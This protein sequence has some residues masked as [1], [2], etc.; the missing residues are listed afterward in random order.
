M[1]HS[2]VQIKIILVE[3]KI[4][5]IDVKDVI[6]IVIVVVKTAATVVAKIAVDVK[7][8][9]K[10]KIISGVVCADAIVANAVAAT[11]AAKYF[12]ILDVDLQ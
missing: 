5:A 6:I 7:T 8:N 3:T 9:V 4:T 11:D 12:W 2:N 10:M 1:I